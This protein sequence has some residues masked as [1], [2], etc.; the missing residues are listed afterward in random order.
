MP[1]LKNESI[2]VVGLADFRRELKKLDDNGLIDGLKDV[3]Y[4]V[5]NSVVRW[6]Q[7]KASTRMEHRAAS[8]L[9]AARAQARASVS[10]GGMRAKFAAGAEFGAMRGIPRTTRRGPVVGWNQ[11][12][13]WRGNGAD[14]GYFLFPAIR[15][16]ERE[17]V[18]QY[19]D[20]IEKLAR[21]AF[22]D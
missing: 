8:T 22:P 11:F 20:A 2:R 10:L 14:A 19:G 7:A 13:Q 5:A 4:D 9:T 6:A 21:K 18:D 1:T 16:H 3:N 12:K 17:I 15:D